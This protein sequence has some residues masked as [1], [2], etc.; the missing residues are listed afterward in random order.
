LRIDI[1]ALKRLSISVPVQSV[2]AAPTAA[3]AA[4][5]A[6]SAVPVLVTLG[7]VA[8]FEIAQ[9]PNQ[10]SRENGKRRIVITANVRGRDLGSFVHE[11]E[12]MITEKVRIPP[13]YWTTWGGQFEQMML[14]AQRLQIVIPVALGLIFML[15]YT[16]FGN[17]RDGLLMFTGV[18]FAL[19]GGILA[20]WLR[21]IP[22][23]ISAGVGFIALSGV[24]VLNGLMMLAFIRDLREKGLLLD[25]AIQTGAMTRLRPVLMTALVASI[26]FLPMALA[27][28]TG[29]EVQR[30][31]ATVVIGGILSSTTLTL[32]VLPVLYRIV[33][34]RD[35]VR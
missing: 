22:L 4:Q 17:M 6:Q 30:P 16:M 32:L 3:Q 31:L 10:I 26:G 35:S 18:P 25:D 14:A 20:L 33:H 9:G 21:D 15:L 7:E 1:E 2:A 8:N 29:A 28:G 5:A 12:Q 24:A 34:G 13:G 27:T 23:S 19:T 11:A